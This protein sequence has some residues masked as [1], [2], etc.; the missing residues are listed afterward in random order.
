M[1][2]GVPIALST[3]PNTPLERIVVGR[4]RWFLR[5]IISPACWLTLEPASGPLATDGSLEL[6]EADDGTLRLR[7]PL[8]AGDVPP[9]GRAVLEVMSTIAAVDAAI[10]TITAVVGPSQSTLLLRGAGVVSRGRGHLLFGRGVPSALAAA[11]R[12]QRRVLGETL[13]AVHANTAG[14]TLH[15][16]PF[17]AA[18]VRADAKAPLLVAWMGSSVASDAVE[19]ASASQAAGWVIEHAALPV[20][21]ASVMRSAFEL[22][23][24][25]ARHG[26]AAATLSLGRTTSWDRLDAL[27]AAVGYRRI[28]GIEQ[29]TLRAALL[30]GLEPSTSD[31]DA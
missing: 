1:I 9:S 8:F 13:V 24:D 23:T 17:R 11:S 10:E 3:P 22:A 2:G 30:R 27:G 16:T 6:V 18:G 7:H 4:Y 28:L 26:T 21:I 12:A 15:A 29:P 19:P 5:S 14:C 20:R 25:V 31:E